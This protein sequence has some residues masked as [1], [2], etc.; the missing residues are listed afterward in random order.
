M[1]QDPRPTHEP[2]SARRAWLSLEGLA[3]GDAFGT[4]LGAAGPD[5]ALRRALPPPVWRW[6]DDT[7]MATS[8]THA[9]LTH[10]RIAQDSLARLFAESF[11]RDPRRGYGRGAV[12][13]LEAIGAGEP[14]RKAARSAFGG[15]G[16]FGNGAAM[17][18][19]PIGAFFADDLATARDEA[20]RSAEITHAHAEGAAGA[21]AVAVAAAA[22][23]ANPGSASP[24]ARGELLDAAI[25][26]TPEGPTRDGVRA[27]RRLR[28]AA[29]VEE[30]V[31]LLG[32]GANVSAAD[33][34]P[35]ALWC[36]ARHLDDLEAALWTAARCGGDADT[37]A[38]IVGG[39]VSLAVG[40]EGLPAEWLRRR[41]GLPIPR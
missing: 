24:R 22:V 38:S 18:A 21:I 12:R 14:W 16:S 34:V 2:P 8:V 35:F 33:T 39:I 31:R 5:F 29:D 26:Y 40:W 4:A 32:N 27:A 9:L 19:G 41:E 13:V 28:R 15:E 10:G 17:R 25:E 1:N 37:I 3:L 11:A 36:A 23:G 30:G 6:T 7:A 20:I